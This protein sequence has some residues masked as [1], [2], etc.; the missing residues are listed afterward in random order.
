MKIIII[1]ICLICIYYYLTNINNIKK[2]KLYNPYNGYGNLLKD[3]KNVKY[4]SGGIPKILIKTSWHNR[5]EFPEIICNTLNNNK[6]INTDYKLY[7]FDNDEVEEFMKSY[8]L[9]AYNAYKKLIPKAYRA[10]LF[11][12]CLLEK[13]GGCYSDIGHIF[14]K[15][16]DNICENN[17]LVL[18]EDLNKYNIH[19]ALIC[20]IPHNPLIRKIIKQCIKN[21]ENNFY[22]NYCLSITGPELV[23]TIFNKYFKNYKNTKILKLIKYN[24]ELFIINKNNEKI[25]KT[26]F[27]NYYNVM[28]KNSNEYY[29]NLWL[30]NNVYNF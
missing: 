12:Y 5:N 26:K 15:S 14:Y 6:N 2:I 17:K 13:Y 25:I 7:Y 20:T 19:N 30:N 21:I 11:R 9:R 29:V 10:D 27:E 1:F 24:N 23:G 18:V 8:S 4:T 28:Y 16:L 3:Y 22:G